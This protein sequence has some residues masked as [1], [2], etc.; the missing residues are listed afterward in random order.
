MHF[1]IEI[2]EEIVQTVYEV[3]RAIN[4]SSVAINI[5]FKRTNSTCVNVV[6][7]SRCSD[8]AQALFTGD[9][10]TANAVWPCT[11]RLKL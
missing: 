11:R 7:T 4:Q 2:N 8:L 5:A 1:S 9:I 6:K 10:A 3:R